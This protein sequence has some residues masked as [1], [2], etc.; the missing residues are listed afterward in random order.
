MQTQAAEMQS[1]EIRGIRLNE[2]M[3]RLLIESAPLMQEWSWSACKPKVVGGM[4]EWAKTHTETPVAAESCDWY[5]GAWQFLRLLDMVAVPPWY[6]FYNSA[7]SSVLRNKPGA[8][9]LISAC[10]DFGMLATL[11]QAM[12]TANTRPEISI[13]DICETPLRNCR[14]YA[15][16]HGLQISCHCDNIL[17]SQNMPLGGFDLI[18]TDEFLTVLKNEY[19]PIIT[20]RWLQLLAPG[21]SVV[22]TAMIGKPT[23]P[24]LR[25]AYAERARLL[26]Q[27][28][29]SALRE[30]RASNGELLELFNKFADFHTR[31]MLVDEAEIRSLFSGFHL[32]F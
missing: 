27:T 8:R 5:H 7:L 20:E 26:M 10:A 13:Y 25:Q 15:D 17:T 28:D 6:E 29:G 32:T 16:R 19:K 18:V 9:V 14:W 2:R 11:H 21:G 23:T 31:H 30:T 24:E 1:D 12:E 4:E 3:Q 22:T